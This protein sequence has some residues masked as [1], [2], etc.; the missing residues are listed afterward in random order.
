MLH[1]P[2][3]KTKAVHIIAKYW[4]ISIGNDNLYVLN[5]PT[6]VCFPLICHTFYT[7]DVRNAGLNL[8]VINFRI[9]IKLVVTK[10]VQWTKQEAVQVVGHIPLTSHYIFNY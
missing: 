10:L 5:Q 7:S 6:Y 9:R 3:T 8:L 1:Y 4:D 2:G